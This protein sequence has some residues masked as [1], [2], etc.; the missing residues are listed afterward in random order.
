MDQPEDELR[1]KDANSNTNYARN[2]GT[3]YVLST[4]SLECREGDDLNINIRSNTF[5]LLTNNVNGF[6]TINEGNKFLEELTI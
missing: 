2:T 4:E 5:C 3:A 6:N 1:V